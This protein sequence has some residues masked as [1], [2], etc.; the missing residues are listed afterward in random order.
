MDAREV[1]GWLL[2]QPRPVSLRIEGG[3]GQIHEMEITHGQRWVEL[4]QSV[5]ALQPIKIEAFDAKNKL[6]RACRPDEVETVEREP[7]NASLEQD[8]ENARLITFARLLSDAYRYSTE[9]AFDKLGALFDAVVARSN[10]QEKT[11]STLDRMVQKL[12]LDQVAIAA[13]GGGG[14]G[15]DDGGPLTLETLL[16]GMLQGRLQAESERR[17]VAATT[18]N[19]APAVV[20]NGAP[21]KPTTKAAKK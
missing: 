12:T 14:G 5:C 16:Q 6:L 21:D 11:I 17:L 10:S 9:V 15:V 3:D 2:C 19:G 4:A 8:P 18:T 13:G 1:R 20:V 7:R